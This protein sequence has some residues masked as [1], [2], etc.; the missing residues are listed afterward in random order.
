[1]DNDKTKK[2]GAVMVVGGGISGMQSALDLANSGYKV[3]LVERSTA[4]GGRMSQLDKTFPTNDCSM[5]MISPKLIEVAKHRNIELITNAEVESVEGQAGNFKVKVLKKPR[6]IDL[7]KCSGCGD[8]ITACPVEMK[9]EFE[10]GL[11]KRKATHK[12]YPQAVPGAFAITK[13]DRPPCKLSCPAGCN[14][15][16]YIALTSKGKYLESLEHIKQWIPLPAVIGRICHHPCEQNCN[17]NEVDQ[18]LGIAPIKAFVADIVRQKRKEGSLPPELKPAIDPSKPKVAVVGAGPSGLTAAYDLVKHGYPVTIFEATSKPGGALQWAIPSYRLP[19]NVVADDIRDIIDLGVELKLNSPVNDKNSLAALEAQ[20]YK[21]VYLAIGA[22]KSRGL[23]IPGVD[24]NGVRLALDFL[25]NTIEGQT[26]SPGKKVVVVGG[27]NVAIDVARTARR[28][29][30]VEVELVCLETRQEMPAHSWEISE[31]EEEGIQINNSWGPREIWGADGKVASIIFQKCLSVYDKDKKFDPRY[32]PNTLKKFECDGVILAIGQGTDLSAL[33]KESK[34][35]A[36]PGG[37]IVADS[38]TLATGEE[39][40]FAGG[41]AVTGPKSGVEAIAHGHEAA[42]SIERYLAGLDLKKDREK[43]KEPA[44]PLPAGQ[45]P[46]LKRVPQRVINMEKRLSSFEEFC[47]PY[48]EEEAK[49]EADRCLNCGLCSECLQCV[50]VCQAKA[51]DHTQK[52][53]HVEIPVG[54]IVVATGFDPFDAKL[55][56]EYGYGRM[57]NV[58]TSLE[59][60]RIL[61]ASGPF[62]GQVKRP[63]DGKHPVKIAWIQCVGSRDVACGKDYCSSV[64]CMYATKEAII[65]REHESTIRPTIFYNDI[66]AFGKGFERYYESAKGKFGVRYV[67]SI[68]STVKE[69]QQSHNLLMEYTDDRG[70]KVQEEFDMVVLSVGLVPAAGTKELAEKMGV[71]LDRFGFCE[72]DE[73]HPNVTSRPGIYAAGAFTAPIDIPESVMSA[74]GAACLAGQDIA[75]ARGTLVTEKIYP[76]ETEVAEEEARVGVFICRCGS[77]IA[78]VVDVPKVLEFAKTVPHVVHAEENIYT[79]STDTQEKVIKA[80]RD[81]NLN[82]IVVASCSPRTHEPLFQDTI[83]EGGLNKYLFEMANIRDQCSWVHATHM[84]ESTEKAKDLVKMAVARAVT[85]LP[86]HQQRAEVTRRALI[87]GGGLSGLTAARGIA[88]QGFE[89]VLV[90]REKELGGNAR[91]IYFTDNG[92]HPQELLRTMI[93]QVESD[94][95]IKVYKGANVTNI[96]GYLGN[97]AAEILLE[98]GTAQKVEHG[99]A[100][101]ATGGAEYKPVEYCYGRSH[102]ILTQLELEKKIASAGARLRDPKSVVMIQCVGSREPEHQYCSRVCCSQAISNAIKLKEINP[103]IEVYVL[104]RDIRTY[105][106]HELNYRKARDLGVTFIHFDSEK[107]PEVSLKNDR[108]H[109]KVLDKALDREIALD[110]DLLVLSA[111]I[112][113]QADAK[114]FASRLKLPLT[115]EEFIMEAHMK[116]RPLDLTNEGMYTCGLAHSP[117]NVSESIAQAQGAV[118]RALTVLSQP[119]LMVGGVVSVVDP[120]KCVACLTCVRACPYDVP[121]INVEGVSYIEPAACQGCGICASVCPRKAITLQNYS[122]KQVTAKLDA[123]AETEPAR[124]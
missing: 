94:P 114:D 117:K 53:G 91:H 26:T 10:M 36:T 62:Q 69:L 42:I 57:P 54:S 44:A 111:A 78:R 12:R 85:L 76:P 113:P 6:Y 92:S 31:A 95:R 82:R 81:K 106:L 75:E 14:G 68:P 9:N 32:D 43:T 59:F 98:N 29:G 90:E 25:R 16:G 27:G 99:V 55:K 124:S 112:R 80:I 83:R 119:Y 86:L 20:G 89:A 115:Q 120:D 58:V 87:I 4:I 21:A 51:I 101:I 72:T 105:G 104:Y 122:D 65:A 1:M 18:P 41:D 47:L 61:S 123:L 74:S 13:G 7:A 28:L 71:K 15:Q 50:S 40:I 34:I 52:A 84:P 45:H 3:Y 66:R 17:R 88:T 37:W 5:C 24:L 93:A 8:C 33:P 2:I 35:K 11:N 48:N 73:M 121:R 77:N 108:I 67:N 96:S 60:E 79:C 97:F 30:A 49:R 39:G 19:K 110:P 109:V 102:N 103:E 64:C 118:S 38:L 107:K 63:S 116:L 56:G 70:K 46:R 22:V 100:V 23:P